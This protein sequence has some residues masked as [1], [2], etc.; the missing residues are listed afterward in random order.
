MSS[1]RFDAPLLHD[2]V[3][4]KPGPCVC[5]KNLNGKP[6]VSCNRLGW[7]ANDRGGVTGI[8]VPCSGPRGDGDDTRE[9]ESPID[10]AT[11]RA[12]EARAK[13]TRAGAP[14]GAL[15]KDTRAVTKADGTMVRGTAVAGGTYVDEYGTMRRR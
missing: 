3:L 10:T 1:Q 12:D 7:K 8:L 5:A 4:E 13:A 9:G 2:R 11:R 15:T 6:G 14:E